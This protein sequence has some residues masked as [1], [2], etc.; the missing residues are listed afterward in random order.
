MLFRSTLKE[1]ILT[2]ASCKGAVKARQPL[3]DIEMLTLLHD[4]AQSENAHTC[5]HGRPIVYKLS[6]QELYRIFK[7]G[8]YIYD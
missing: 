5:P 1:R 7:R 2:M 6:M 8:S 4:L 3:T